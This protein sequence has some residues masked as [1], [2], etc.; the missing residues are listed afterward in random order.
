MNVTGDDDAYNLHLRT[1]DVTRPWQSYRATFRP[2]PEWRTIHLPFVDFTA[3]RI[4]A[5]LDLSRFRR[6]DIV[7][8]GRAF[9]AD[10]VMGGIRFFS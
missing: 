4:D 5:P 8:I 1:T 3:H 10:L 7:A 9:E 6:I 2:T